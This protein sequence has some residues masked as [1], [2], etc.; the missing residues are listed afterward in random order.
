MG[1]K[2]A[3]IIHSIN[4]HC[5]AANVVKTLTCALGDVKAKLMKVGIGYF[6][7]Y[8]LTI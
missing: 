3:T 5:Y 4:F 1:N 7:E 2:V 6:L 8:L